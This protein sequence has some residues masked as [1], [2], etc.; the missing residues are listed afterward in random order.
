MSEVLRPLRRE[1]DLD[2][3]LAAE[4]A[5]IYKHSTR[6]F[7]SSRAYRQVVRFAKK[8]DDLPVFIVDV[9]E[10]RSLSQLIAQRVGVVHESP[11]TLLLVEGV[12]VWS[13]SHR[14]VSITTLDA[15]LDSVAGAAS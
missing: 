4:R 11:Q 9:I 10:D 1:E 12:V 5:L 13:A 3:V 15:A 14:D 6:C 2:Q 8:H 7:Q